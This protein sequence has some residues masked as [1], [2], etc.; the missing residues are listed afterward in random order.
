MNSYPFIFG[1][2]AG[3]A[4]GLTVRAD[5]TSTPNVVYIGTTDHG[6]GSDKDHDIT[7]ITIG[8]DGLSTSLTAIGTWDDRLTLIYT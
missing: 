5:S 2:V 4:A 1:A 6:N 7:Q 8:L 3:G